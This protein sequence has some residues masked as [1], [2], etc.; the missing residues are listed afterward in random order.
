MFVALA[1]SICA[2]GRATAEILTALLPDSV[3]GYDA[4]PGIT[5][6]TGE[7]PEQMPLGLREGPVVLAPKLE[8]SAG[9]DSNALPGPHRRGSWEIT[10]GATLAA[11]TETSQATVGGV[12]SLEDRRELALP[13][14]SRT[15][16][17]VSA[18]SRIA[19]GQDE[20][21]VA[22]AHVERHEDRGEIATI[23]SDRPVAFRVDDVRI[24]YTFHRARWSLTPDLEATD[25]RYDP[26]TIGGLPAD[27]SYRNRLVFQAGVTLRYELAPLRDLVFVVRGIGQD[28]T[29]TPAGQVNPGSRSYQF[30]AGMSDQTDPVWHWRLLIGGEVRS[31]D[32]PL[33]RPQN[34]LIAEGGA[35]W[36]PSATT[37]V[38]ATISR[39]TDAATEE[40]VSG[41][42][43]M[44][45]R[46]AIAH[47][48]RRNLLLN[49]WAAWQQQDDFQ[50][51]YQ[52]GTHFGL[53]LTWMVN[54]MMR[55]ALT[56]DQIDLRGSTQAAGATSPGYSRGLGLMSV[57][58]GL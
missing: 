18:G 51:G 16:G 46:L 39:E 27:Q 28:Y 8:E 21:T 12:A 48:L 40:G 33:Y 56:Y 50:G 54:R 52:A 37:T 58:M 7:H 29:D 35:S 17:S 38:W 41:L 32:A 25:W 23:P 42:T 2:I 47:E 4:G 26:T 34:T 31:F 49:G 45:A 1:G 11:S 13:A 44:A 36:S 3:P 57:R 24:G 30:L 5:V 14:Q 10:T 53:S 43:Y 9:Y 55:V 22:L 20:A 19:V 6:E 15:D